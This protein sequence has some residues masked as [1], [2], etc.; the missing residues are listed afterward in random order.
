[1]A[2]RSLIYV[3]LFS[4]FLLVRYTDGYDTTDLEIFDLVEEIGL[5]Q[6][7]YDLLQISQVV[8][9]YGH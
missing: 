5:Q 6:S 7:F 9:K 3:S 1:M 8:S 2:V 4:L